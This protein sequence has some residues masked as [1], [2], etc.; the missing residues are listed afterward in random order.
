MGRGRGVPALAGAMALLGACEVN[1][2]VGRA[3]TAYSDG[4]YLEVAESLERHEND[5]PT[6][7]AD[8]QA[9]YGVFRGLALLRL[10]D[11]EGAQRWLRWA[12]EVEQQQPSLTS[13]QRKL[14]DTGLA[15]VHRL[16]TPPPP[17]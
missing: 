16:V 7:P 8:R 1:T 11:Y 13:D 12:S 5:V 17:H 10:G 14:L 6:L 2:Y 15:E 4:R 3:E 9:R